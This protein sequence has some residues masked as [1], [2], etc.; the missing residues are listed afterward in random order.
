LKPLEKINRKGNR[1]SRKIGKGNSTQGSPLSLARARPRVFVPDRGT[2]HVG[3]NP[4]ALS[5]SLSRCSVGLTYR[6]R[7]SHPRPLSPSLC[8]AVPTY[9]CVPNLSPTISPSWTRPRPR[10]LRPRPSPRAPFEPRALLTHLPSSICALYLAL[11]PSLSLY[12]REPRTSA[13][14][15]RR[16]PPISWPPLRP[17]PVQ[18]H[19]KLRLAVSYS[20]QPSVCPFPP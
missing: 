7:C 14:A 18:S 12:P 16:P 13:I 3:A 9:Q 15:R 1:N 17:C 19:S 10:V 8:P 20:G 2:P 11:S 5:P 6:C 4:S